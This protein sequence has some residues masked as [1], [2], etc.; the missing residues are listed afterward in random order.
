MNTLHHTAA[1][2]NPFSVAST[3]EMTPS[4]ITAREAA[5]DR[6]LVSRFRAGEESAF[7][8]I[9][10]RYRTRIFGLAN[11]LLHNAADAEEITQDTFI[12][13][14]RALANFRGDSSLA[15]WLYRIALNLSR[16]RYWYFFRRRRQ[17]SISL[18]MQLGDDSDSAFSDMIAATAHTP[19]QE[20]V[21]REFTNLIADCMERLDTRHREILTMRNVLNLPYDEIASA[22]GINV[23]TVKSRIA[24]ARE[25]LR[26]LLSESAPEYANASES[27]DFFEHVRPAPGCEAIAYA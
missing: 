2:A 4:E 22:L 18:E 12:R 5:H 15:T 6:E 25:S 16:N 1:S 7:T 24:R 10:E 27:S 17:D 19:V 21:T 8:E 14:H 23:G 3:P 9:M 13:A 11:N 20:A 26:K